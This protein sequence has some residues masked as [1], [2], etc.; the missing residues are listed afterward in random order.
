MYVIDSIEDG[1]A[2]LEPLDGGGSIRVLGAWLP[3][4]AREGDVVTVRAARTDAGSELLLA[5]DPEARRRREA[6]IRAAHAALPR[7]PGGDI[8]L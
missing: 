8:E 6:E 2:L 3:P 7:A 1:M 5:L 4:R